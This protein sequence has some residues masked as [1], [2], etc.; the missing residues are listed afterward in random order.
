M[1][2]TSRSRQGGRKG[3]RE[4][5]EIAANL[6]REASRK[7]DRAVSFTQQYRRWRRRRFLAGALIAIGVFVVFSHVFV[8]L[9]NIQWLPTTG[10]QDLVTGY[11]MGAVL[12]V[13]G[14]IL[15]GTR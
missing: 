4:S 14:L 9:A 3:R 2:K 7:A 13:L 1:P 8:H 11:P 10:L 12:I 6:Q 5:R 15:L